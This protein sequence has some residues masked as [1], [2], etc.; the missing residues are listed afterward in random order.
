MWTAS[1]CVCGREGQKEEE[2]MTVVGINYN[3]NRWK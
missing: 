1:A 2:V 3:I